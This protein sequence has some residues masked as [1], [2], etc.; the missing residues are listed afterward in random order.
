GGVDCG[1]GR[2]KDA[3]AGT[4]ADLGRVADLTAIRAVGER[5]TVSDGRSV[6]SDGEA[7]ETGAFGAVHSVLAVISPR[8]RF[9]K[10]AT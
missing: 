3:S 2:V 4:T 6:V 1:R 9:S 5:A 8:V 7:V 10:N